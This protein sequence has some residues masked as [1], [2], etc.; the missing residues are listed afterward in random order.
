MLT[1]WSSAG[2]TAIVKTAVIPTLA[3]SDF[4]CMNRNSTGR[5]TISNSQS[6]DVVVPL[7]VWSA[8]FFST[9]LADWAGQLKH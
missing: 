3:S 7:I 5:F 6:T 1:R 2:A 9:I 4:T 8:P